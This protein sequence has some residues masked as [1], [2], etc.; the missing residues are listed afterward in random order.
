[1]KTPQT[2]VELEEI[3]ANYK[4]Y[5][6]ADRKTTAYIGLNEEDSIEALLAWRNKAVE[7][8]R[9]DELERLQK[10]HTRTFRQTVTDNQG[11]VYVDDSHAYI[12][13][14]E[15]QERIAELKS[16]SDRSE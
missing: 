13:K 2:D 12:S 7:E 5:L 8:V 6:R 9:I 15:T 16:N 10:L 3:L 1:M 11:A 14:Y 4:R